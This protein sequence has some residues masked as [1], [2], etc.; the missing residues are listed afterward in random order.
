MAKATET[1][2]KFKKVLTIFHHC[3]EIYDSNVVTDAQIE[4]LGRVNEDTNYANSWRAIEN[5]SHQ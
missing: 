3:H 2:A 4:D 1:E 5:R